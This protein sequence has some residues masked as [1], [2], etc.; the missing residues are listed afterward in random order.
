M[1]Q[2]TSYQYDALGRL[3]TILDANSHTTGMGYDE[4]GRQT[5]KVWPDGSTERYGYDVM[6]NRISQALSDGVITNTF[7]Y[8]NLNRLRQANY[9]SAGTGTLARTVVYTYTATGQRQSINDSTYGTTSYSYDNRDRVVQIQQ[10]AIGTVVAQSVGYGYDE[11]SNR[12]VMTT[13]APS[14]SLVAS[15]NYGYDAVGR[16]QS[17][18]GPNDGGTATI[19]SYYENGLR[20]QQTLP[21]G[22]VSTY[23]YDPLNRLT[24]ITQGKSGASPLLADYQ[25]ALDG[26]GNRTAITETT[27]Y[28]STQQ[29]RQ[30]NY[31]YDP[32]YRLT[33]EKDTLQAGITTTYGYDAAGNRLG[34]TVTNGITNSVTRSNYNELDQIISSVGPNLSSSYS[35]VRGNLVGVT[36]NGATTAYTWD[37][38]ARL[39]RV[40][41]PGSVN[42]TYGYDADGRRVTQIG[43]GTGTTNINL[44][45]LWDEQSQYGD[46]VLETDSSSGAARTSYVLSGSQGELISQKRA[47]ASVADYFLRDGQGSTRALVN[48]TG[49][50][51]NG[52]NYGYSA[53]GK[54]LSGQTNSSAAT[55]YQYTGQQFDSLSG[56]YDLRARYYNP[57]EGHFLSRDQVEAIIFEPNTLQKYQYTNSNPVSNFDPTGNES[58]VSYG[59]TSLAVTIRNIV[60]LAAVGVAASCTL[61]MATMLLGTI[62]VGPGLELILTIPKLC[63][64][65]QVRVQLQEN[66]PNGG[67]TYSAVAVA[68]KAIGV[69]VVQVQFALLRL[70]STTPSWFPMNR[71]RFN[72]M[73]AISSASKDLNKFPP[74]GVAGENLNILREQIPSMSGGRTGEYRLDIENMHGHNLRA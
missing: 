69:L 67:N 33:S 54:L 7:S 2:P 32:A 13:T 24:E 47:G 23:T 57:G 62:F 15:T 71:L 19:Y 53:F 37:S 50:L 60:R 48:N 20:K 58:E 12:T 4:L 25:Y 43:T 46:V 1:G 29:T 31:G 35:Y 42:L 74:S 6:G 65:N 30:M 14:A 5:T 64:D 28:T 16:L 73:G 59:Q 18:L 51:L 36:T 9:A 68:P 63:A 3:S 11:R 8:D 41:L 44:N 34:L 70:F 61:C 55:N 66:I 72:L 56:L 27:N 40:A 17:V 49:V 52:Q 21:N 26:A 45:Y 10:P 22:I 39:V 38:A